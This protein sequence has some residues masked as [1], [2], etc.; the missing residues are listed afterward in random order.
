ML[1]ATSLCFAETDVYS[2]D[3]LAKIINLLLEVNPLPTLL[4]R[5]VIQTLNLHPKLLG[6]IMNIL[7]RLIK[8]QVS[9]NL[10]ILDWF[11]LNYTSVG[12][13]ATQNLG[14]ICKMLSA[15]FAQKH[16]DSAHASTRAVE[17]SFGG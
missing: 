16:S 4:M 9:L 8:K 10:K 13:D 7:A 15:D 6:F 11:E 5:T 2:Q 1:P 12:L 3:V 14:G 17:A